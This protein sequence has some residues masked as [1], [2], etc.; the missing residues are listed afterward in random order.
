MK[1]DK[2]FEAWKK[3]MLD[4]K[5]IA[6]HCPSGRSIPH[7]IDEQIMRNEHIREGERIPL[8]GPSVM[9]KED[10]YSFLEQ[11][12]SPKRAEHDCA[13]PIEPDPV[14]C[15]NLCPAEHKYCYTCERKLE[16][17][18]IEAN[19]R[20]NEISQKELVVTHSCEGGCGGMCPSEYRLCRGCQDGA[21]TLKKSAHEHLQVE[22]TEIKEKWKIATDTAQSLK[23]SLTT[24]YTHILEGFLIDWENG[25]IIK[26]DLG[27]ELWDKL[28]KFF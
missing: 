17:L 22:L 16:E 26:E 15:P 12:I 13:G 10:V 19:T 18:Y 7:A 14:P 9:L 21:D 27:P 20:L 2:I 4:A 6:G 24:A 11:Y 28:N 23:G 25:T 3:G 5:S 1:D 8:T